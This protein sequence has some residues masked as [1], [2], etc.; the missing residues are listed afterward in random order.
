MKFAFSAAVKSL[1]IMSLQCWLNCSSTSSISLRRLKLT[2]D[3][4]GRMAVLVTLCLP[5]FA[6]FDVWQEAQACNL[7]AAY[8]ILR[9]KKYFPSARLGPEKS[10]FTFFAIL[11]YLC[12]SYIRVC[13][14]CCKI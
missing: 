4:S 1:P 5:S 8:L 13:G 14:N 9:L 11:E 7:P 10:A 3:E 6:G 12:V 2:A